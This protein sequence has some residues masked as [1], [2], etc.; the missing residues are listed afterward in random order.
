MESQEKHTD[1][2]EQK[3]NSTQEGSNGFW[4]WV[5]FGLFAFAM[6]IVYIYNS[7]HSNKALKEKNNLESDLKELNNEKVFLES[8]VTKASKQ[9]EVSQKLSETGIKPLNNPPIKIEKEQKK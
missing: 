5:R 8:Q 2:G 9:T 7:N 3:P 6:L 4:G 1:L